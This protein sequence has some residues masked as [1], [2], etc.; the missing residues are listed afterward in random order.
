MIR[1]LFLVTFGLFLTGESPAQLTP[2]SLFE[3][4]HPKHPAH[5]LSLDQKDAFNAHRAIS[6]EQFL[7]KLNPKQ[8]RD[9]VSYRDTL[10]ANLLAAQHLQFPPPKGYTGEKHKGWTVFVHEEL[11]ITHPEKTELALRLLDNQLQDI[12]DRIPGPAVSYLKKVPLWFSPSKDGKGGACHHPSSGWLKANGF[13]VAFSKTIEFS[14]IPNFERETMRMPNFALHELAHAYHNHLLGDEHQ[15]LLT[16]YVRAKK[17]GSYNNVPKRT[18][19][20]NNPLKIYRGPAYAMNN[21][22]EYFAETTEAYFC[23]NDITPYDRAALIE[24]DPKVVPILEKVWGVKKP[25]PILL[26]SN[27]ILFL[28]DSIT[29]G[30]HFIHDLQA[31]LHLKGHAP[32]VIA[33]GLSSETLCGL[34]EPTHPFPRPDLQERL[35]RALAKVKPDLVFACYGMN[36]GIYHPFS[37]ERFAAYQ[38]GVNTLIA[39]VNKAGAKLILITPPPFDPLAPGAQKS[40]LPIDAAEFSWNNIYRHYDRDVISPYATWIGKQA[41]RVEAVIDVHSPISDLLKSQRQ[42]NPKFTMSGDGIHLDKTGHREM[43]RAIYL[44]LFKESLPELPDELVAFYRNRQEIL[45]PAWMSHIGHKRP[46][47]KP[48]LPLPEAQARA[49]HVLR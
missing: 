18:G 28:G 37:E 26:R 6:N 35:D 48:G 41:P 46:G 30:R 42:K 38:E 15:E 40:T 47:I 13:P 45:S 33:A 10:A 7:A 3:K 34:S 31:A 39:K 4:R 12:I 11:K 9:L 17:S 16:S 5:E 29:A 22:M 23:E 43:A 8:L 21:Q 14:N 44:T 25:S 27:R 20:P 2:Y 49:A 32:E 19:D 24:H 36:E 1:V